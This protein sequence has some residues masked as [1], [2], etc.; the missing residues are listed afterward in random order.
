MPSAPQEIIDLV[1]RFA[2]N[3]DHYRS[4]SYNETQVRGEFLDP[5][6]AAL[7]WDVYNQAGVAP[8]YQSVIL[9]ATLR[10]PGSNTTMPDYCFR[11]GPERKFF[12]EVKEPSVDIDSAVQPAY[13]LRRY[14]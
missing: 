3:A 7:G 6:F 13:Q 9:Q 2:H 5:F 1:E 12:V 11:V 14:A 10:T 8:S 4:A